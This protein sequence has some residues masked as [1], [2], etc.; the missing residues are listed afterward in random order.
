MDLASRNPDYTYTPIMFG[1]SD[2]RCTGP[3][4]ERKAAGFLAVGNLIAGLLSA[5]TSPKIGEL[6]DLYGRVRMLTAV[7]SSS[8]IMEAL[9]VYAATQTQTFNVYWLYVGWIFEGLGGSFIAGM[10]LA[11]SYA[12][13]TTTPAKRNL[14][15]GYFH[16]CLFTGIALGPI[17]ASRL[18][19]ETGGIAIVF[20]IALTFHGV[21]IVCMA[22]VIPESLTKPRQ[23]AAQE[24]RRKQKAD[25]RILQHGNEASRIAYNLVGIFRPLKTLYPKGPGSSSALRR[26]LILLAAIDFIVFS[27]A[28]GATNVVTIYIRKQFDWDAAQQ[29]DFISAVNVSRVLMLVIIMPLIIKLFRSKL[30]EKSSDHL[31]GCDNLDLILIRAAVVFDTVGYLGYTLARKPELFTLS[32]IVASLGGMA[33]PTLQSALTK[34]VPHD[35]TGQL[36]GASGLLH[37]MGRVVSPVVFNS[38][39]AATNDKFRQTVFACLTGAFCLAFLLASILRTGTYLIDEGVSDAVDDERS[40]Q[41]P[42]QPTSVDSIGTT[43]VSSTPLIRGDDNT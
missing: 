33:S 34:H 11:N 28:M 6:S 7:V 4:I 14:A 26:N 5:I 20:I 17:V 41:A 35:R 32:G 16:G 30:D 29:S 3:I 25:D 37:A 36:L 15:F 22:L 2:S 8:L 12:T 38:I 39:F 9:T 13:D 43:R 19:R 21:F 23:L 24:R 18:M 31:K 27:V 1:Q 42:L 10:A 40:G